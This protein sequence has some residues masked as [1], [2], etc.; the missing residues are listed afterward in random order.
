MNLGAQKADI[1]TVDRESLVDIRNVK[2]DPGLSKQDRI[3]S[4]VNNYNFVHKTLFL[5]NLFSCGTIGI[6]TIFSA[7]NT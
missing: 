6:H 7:A 2:I 1:R 4:F 5:F 3:K